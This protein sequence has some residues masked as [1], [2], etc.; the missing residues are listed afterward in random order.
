MKKI[1]EIDT[2]LFIETKFD[3]SNTEIFDGKEEPFSVHGM[4]YINGSFR[5]VTEEFAKSVNDGVLAHHAR[6]AGG[7]IR[8]ATDSNFIYIR[9][10]M[11][12]V[13]DVSH[14]T[15]SASAGFDLYADGKYSGTFIP[16]KGMTEGY[17]S[18]IVFPDK[19]KRQIV[20]N[21]PLYSIVN[22]FYVGLEKG[23]ALE[24]AREYSI[25]VPVVYY[26]SS[27]TQGLCAS[28][29]ANIY[30]E[31]ISRK[32]DC[33]YLNLG[34]SGSARGEKIMSEY[35]ALL[36]QSVFVLDYD[37]NAPDNEFLKNTHETF[38][39]AVREKNPD[40]PIIMMSAP[41]RTFKTENE[42][43]CATIRQT[44]EN[45]LKRGDKNVYFI[46]GRDMLNIADVEMASVDGNHPNDLGFWCMA[47]ALGTTLKNIP[48]FADKR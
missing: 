4:Q 10:V 37:E 8:F 40:L 47:E 31:V 3:L 20:I 13:T 15:F 23:S 19:R 17:E 28:R 18:K 29:P 21:F 35:I 34:F 46:C 12:S 6:C 36:K 48:I 45:A 38:F 25:D 2:N 33:D 7:R 24:K 11:E 14:M 39:L 16:P 1:D 42:E 41:T 30:Q 44:Y 9:T 22:G 43:R 5:R 26:G 27:I 32:F